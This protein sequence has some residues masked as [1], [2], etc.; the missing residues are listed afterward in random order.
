MTE[1]EEIQLRLEAKNSQLVAQNAVLERRCD[2]L[3]QMHNANQRH[4]ET[5]RKEIDRLK[6][7]PAEAL[8]R[9]LK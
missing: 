2:K 8:F 1:E 7:Q 3:Q 5:L 4:I 6:A 9:G